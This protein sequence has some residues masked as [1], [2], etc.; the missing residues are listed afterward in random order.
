MNQKLTPKSSM[1]LRSVALLAMSAVVL[2]SLFQLWWLLAPSGASN[3]TG[4]QGEV[5][6]KA[7]NF[8]RNTAANSPTPDFIRHT[9]VTSVRPIS[10]TEK[11]R[12]CLGQNFASDDPSNARHYVVDLEAHRLF[13]VTAQHVTQYACVFM[14]FDPGFLR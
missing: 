8:Q 6:T 9:I 7:V 1:L 14:S 13:Y 12:F 11:E 10:T 5:A 3:Y 4:I 2:F